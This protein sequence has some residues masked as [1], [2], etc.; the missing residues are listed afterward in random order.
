MKTLICLFVFG[1]VVAAWWLVAAFAD[2]LIAHRL[3]W[4]AAV[5]WDRVRQ[6]VRA[7]VPHLPSPVR[8]AWHGAR[9]GEEVPDAVTPSGDRC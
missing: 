2:T 5:L 4:E 3:G 6:P 1:L 9:T 7:A 8:A